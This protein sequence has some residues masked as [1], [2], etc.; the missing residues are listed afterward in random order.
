MASELNPRQRAFADHYLATGNATQSYIS[1]GYKATEEGAAVRASE[2]LRNVKVREYIAERQSQVESTRILTIAECQEFLSGV[3]TGDEERRADQIKAAE[4]L[5]K[6]QGGF[7]ENV[8]L[9]G[10]VQFN[11]GGLSQTLET[12]KKLR[13]QNEV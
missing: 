3:V 5:I 13:G 12:L 8:N 10:G 11:A 9:K 6:V 2:L 7:T 4:L 1:A